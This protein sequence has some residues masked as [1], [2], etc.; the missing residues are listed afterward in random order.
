MVY[1]TLKSATCSNYAKRFLP[2]R[3]CYRCTAGIPRVRVCTRASTAKIAVT[4]YYARR[5]GNGRYIRRFLFSCFATILQYNNVPFVRAV[6]II[7]RD[8]YW[9]RPSHGVDFRSLP[10][11]VDLCPVDS[12]GIQRT[13]RCDISAWRVLLTCLSLMYVIAVWRLSFRKSHRRLAVP[14]RGRES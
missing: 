14:K 1:C 3:P 11:A 10:F 9:S 8:D 4:V 7:S 12:A 2:R 13:T 6:I 5:A